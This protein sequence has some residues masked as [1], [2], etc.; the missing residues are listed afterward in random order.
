MT[1]I[2]YLYPFDEYP[3]IPALKGDVNLDGKVD[4]TDVNI[5]VNI[6]LGK[7]SADNYDGRALITEG[8]DVVDV[9]DINAV[10]NIVLGK[11]E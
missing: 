5:L 2:V 1:N 4:V 10:V 8:D 11:A 9:S 7:D 6:V 3:E